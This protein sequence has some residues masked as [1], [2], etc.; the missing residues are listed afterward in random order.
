MSS[1]TPEQWTN[2]FLAAGGFLTVAIVP[3]IINIILTLRGNAKVD[4]AKA[5]SAD[6]N[7]KTT[8]IVAQT[9][10]IADAVPG[11]ST[12]PTD[13]VIQRDAGPRADR[14]STDPQPKGQD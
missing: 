2:F 3:A 6:T 4:A 14:R 10:E 11:A 9:R 12:A 5:L 1:W 13:I 8:A 7:Q